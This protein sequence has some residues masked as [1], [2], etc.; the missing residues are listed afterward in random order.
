[1]YIGS[2]GPDSAGA[3]EKCKAARNIF[4]AILGSRVVDVDQSHVQYFRESLHFKGSLVHFAFLILEEN[5]KLLQVGVHAL[6]TSSFIK[7]LKF[8]RVAS[9]VNSQYFQV[10]YLHLFDVLTG[11]AKGGK[12]VIFFVNFVQKFFVVQVS[13]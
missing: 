4:D 10:A 9:S 7:I 13:I 8:R 3:S 6:V 2:G 5:L 1:M 11:R 12:L